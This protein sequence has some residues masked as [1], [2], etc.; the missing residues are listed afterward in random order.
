VLVL[1]TLPDTLAFLLVQIEPNSTASASAI[2]V[3][4][5]LLPG[6]H[7]LRPEFGFSNMSLGWAEF[8]IWARDPECRVDAEAAGATEIGR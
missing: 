7:V 4:H 3:T 6:V 1:S 8:P 2:R 5:E